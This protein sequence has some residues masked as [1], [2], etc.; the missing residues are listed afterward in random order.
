MTTSG[1]VHSVCGCSRWV[2][3]ECVEDVSIDARR[4]VGPSS[5]TSCSDGSN[6]SVII[7]VYRTIIVS[8]SYI[9]IQSK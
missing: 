7:C 5:A 8:N 3:E 4:S 6:I 2:H 1:C 9:I